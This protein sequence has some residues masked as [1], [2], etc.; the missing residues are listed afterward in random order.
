MVQVN[1]H[2]YYI[3]DRFQEETKVLELWF[4]HISSKDTYS[5]DVHLLMIG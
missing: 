2:K 1:D 3:L 5:I 4:T